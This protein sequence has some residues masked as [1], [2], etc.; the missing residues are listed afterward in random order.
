MSRLATARG[1]GM[2]FFPR[3]TH[4]ADSMLV[5]FTEGGAEVTEDED[6]ADARMSLGPAASGS[7]VMTDLDPERIPIGPPLGPRAAQLMA[8]ADE[9]WDLGL[10][11]VEAA[12][13]PFGGG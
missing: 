11:E 3:G 5:R 2:A 1:G 6:L 8:L 13:D 4:E 10:P 12:P 7:I 9:R